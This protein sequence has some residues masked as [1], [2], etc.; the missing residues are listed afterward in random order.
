MDAEFEIIRN[1]SLC[2]NKYNGECQ[3]RWL[4]RGVKNA[5]VTDSTPINKPW[6]RRVTRLRVRVLSVEAS[7]AQCNKD[8]SPS[9]ANFGMYVSGV[10]T[11]L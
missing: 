5:K 6:T 10:D 1:S 4:E 11:K 8:L 3:L 9:L 2:R 7:R